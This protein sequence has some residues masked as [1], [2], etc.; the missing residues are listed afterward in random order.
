MVKTKTAGFGPA[1]L[2]TSKQHQYVML[3]LL[4]PSASK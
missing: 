1:V 3:W 2:K 4:V